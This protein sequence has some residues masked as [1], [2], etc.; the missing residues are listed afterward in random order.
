MEKREITFDEARA[1]AEQE[2]HRILAPFMKTAEQAALSKDYLEAPHCWMFFKNKEIVIPR[3]QIIGNGIP[4]LCAYV[5]S[6]RGEGRLVSDLSDD[7]ERC[8]KYLQEI[9]DYFQSKDR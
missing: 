4:P 5:Y 8:K 3:D 7:P 1:L 9:S 6:K 2:A